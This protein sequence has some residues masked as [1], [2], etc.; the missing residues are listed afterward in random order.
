MA[1]RAFALTV[2]VMTAASMLGTQARAPGRTGQVAAQVTGG[3]H[4]IPAARA[5]D[6]YAIYSL[7]TPGKLLRDVA[8]ASASRWAIAAETVSF[9]D[10][11]PRID[12]RGALKPPADNEKAFQEA[13]ASFE[14]QKNV[15]YRLRHRL[16]VGHPYDLLDAAQIRA[17]REAKSST[18]ADARLRDRYAAYPGVT[19][20]SA[21]YFSRDRKA[22]LVY[23]NDWCGVLCS[24]AQWFYLEKQGGRWEQKSGITVPGA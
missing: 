19:F 16:D 5:A 10:M 8:S 18:D 3:E 6:A 14:R 4:R 9:A 7:L 1:M 22:A 20:F 17:L 12:P 23:R 24:Q 15:R 13:V 2:A 11:D 21:V